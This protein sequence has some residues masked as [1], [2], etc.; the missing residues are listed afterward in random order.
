MLDN[1]VADVIAGIEIDRPLNALTLSCA[2]H[3]CFGV[4]DTHFDAVENQENTY[5]IETFEDN[6]VVRTL[7][8]PVTRTL[9]V[10]K[11][12]TI[13]PPSP[14]LLAVHRAIAHILHL[15]GAGN[16]IEGLGVR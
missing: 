9:S 7:G 6:R 1:G 5:T 3:L 8:L 13:D 12:R 11:T 2:H 4:Y 16:Y 14:R 15:S 10:I